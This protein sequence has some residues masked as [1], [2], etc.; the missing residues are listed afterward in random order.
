MDTAAVQARMEKTV[1]SL[2]KDLAKIR[3]GVASP[4]ML[5]GV[6]VD[7]YGTPTPIS[8]VGS[9]SVPEPR[10]LAIQPF[11]KNMLEAIEKAILMSDLGLNPSN[12][13]AIIRLSLPILTTERRKE[14]AKKVRGVGEDAKV[15]V[16]NIRRDENDSIKKQ[17]KEES[18]SE[19]DIKGQ[20]SEVQDITDSYIKKLEEIVADKEKDI[21]EV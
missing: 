2:K 4:A 15:G 7:Y 19:D 14:L 6:Y 8:H 12:D 13:G 11:E 16:R 10:V 20:M 9:I 21:L 3:T 5:D 17:G 1:E 18:L